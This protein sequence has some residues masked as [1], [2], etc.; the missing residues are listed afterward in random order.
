MRPEMI[1]D[2]SVADCTFA[3][4]LNLYFLVWFLDESQPVLE[5]NHQTGDLCTITD[6]FGTVIVVTYTLPCVPSKRPCHTRHRRFDGTHG[7]VLD[8]HT[9][10]F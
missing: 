1:T 2:F 8:V 5:I 9:G 7:S 4:E 10:A 6:V 3:N